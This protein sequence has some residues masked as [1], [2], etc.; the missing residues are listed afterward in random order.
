M[1]GRQQEKIYIVKVF[2]AT[3]RFEISDYVLSPH[4]YLHKILEMQ[5]VHFEMG[6]KTNKRCLN[7]KEKL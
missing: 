2:V 7:L 3:W 5:N 1:K 4:A 6:M